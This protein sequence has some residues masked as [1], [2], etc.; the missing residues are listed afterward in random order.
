MRRRLVLALAG[1]LAVAGAGAA[2][3][4]IQDGLWEVTAR[5]EMQG[6]PMAMPPTRYSQC[7]TR[8]NPVPPTAEAGQQ[9]RIARSSTQGDTVSW[10]VQ[11]RGPEGEGESTGRVTYRGTSFDGEVT[12]VMK[13]GDETM[14]VVTR[15]SGKR[16]GA[17]K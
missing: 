14:K 12:T 11:C 4:N 10:T 6:A 5:M 8:D 2:A 3:P 16:I 7:L 9:C 15:M 1:V 13:D 17:C